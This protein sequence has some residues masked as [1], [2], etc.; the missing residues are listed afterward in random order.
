MLERI[1]V[2]G[3]PDNLDAALICEGLKTEDSCAS[4]LNDA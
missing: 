1:L 2:R 3:L 4:S